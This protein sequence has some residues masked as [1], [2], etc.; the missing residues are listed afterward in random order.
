MKFMIPIDKANR[1]QQEEQFSPSHISLYFFFFLAAGAKVKCVR[2]ELFWIQLL[3][4]FTIQRNKEEKIF[5]GFLCK[6][7]IFCWK[8]II[9]I[10]TQI[11]KNS[12]TLTDIFKLHK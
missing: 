7:R 3:L 8:E 5:W 6:V 2:V 4:C 11:F 12:N 10:V 9:F 1:V